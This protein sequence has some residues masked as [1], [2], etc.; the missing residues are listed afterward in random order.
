MGLCFSGLEAFAKGRYYSKNNGRDSH[1]DFM[2]T[3]QLGF[4]T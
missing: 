4:L 1:N 3:W 2:E